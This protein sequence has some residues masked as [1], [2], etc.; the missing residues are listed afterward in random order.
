MKSSEVPQDDNPLLGGERKLAYALDEDGR[1]VGVPTD[2][3]EVEEVVTGMVVE[4]FVRQAVEARERVRAGRSAPLEFHM[5]D[6]RMDVQLLAQTV[7]RPQWLVRLHMWPWV[8]RRLSERTLTRY[9]DALG[10][11]VEELQVLPPPG[12]SP[13]EDEP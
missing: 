4:Q 1:Y 10:L 6:R 9:A 3:W 8:F 7:M 11:G 2:G 5:Y 12:E 13:R